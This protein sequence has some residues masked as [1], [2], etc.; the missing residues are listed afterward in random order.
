[1]S[2][3]LSGGAMLI[4]MAIQVPNGAGIAIPFEA[5]GTA[6]YIAHHKDRPGEGMNVSSRETLRAFIR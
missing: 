1:M 3:E 4:Q 5:G 6:F 2:T